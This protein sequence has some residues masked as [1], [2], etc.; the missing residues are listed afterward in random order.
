MF[1]KLLPALLA[2]IYLV[3]SCFADVSIPVEDRIQNIK[4]PGEG[5]GGYCVWC[6]LET[7]GNWKGDKRLSGLVKWYSKW[8]GQ[9]ATSAQVEVQLKELGVKYTLRE[10]GGMAWLQKQVDSGVP[11]MVGCEWT[12]GRHAIV[13]LNVTKERVYFYDPNH[14]EWDWYVPRAWFEKNWYG[15]AVTLP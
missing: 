3:N 4:G 5:P 6:C 11:V 7:I 12:V 14:P 15:M 10:H 13:V 8:P 2:L 9:G 1:R